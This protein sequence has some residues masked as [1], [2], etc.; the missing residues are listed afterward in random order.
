VQESENKP[1]PLPENGQSREQTTEH[2]FNVDELEVLRARSRLLHYQKMLDVYLDILGGKDSRYDKKYFYSIRDKSGLDWAVEIA[3]GAN[4]YSFGEKYS[5]DW[6]LALRIVFERFWPEIKSSYH[7]V[8]KNISETEEP[9]SFKSLLP[10]AEDGLVPIEAFDLGEF[11]DEVLVGLGVDWVF[12]KPFGQEKFTES[13]L[14]SLVENTDSK[15]FYENRALDIEEF[16]RR[17][18]YSKDFLKIGLENGVDINKTLWRNFQCL[19]LLVYQETNF[20]R[21]SELKKNGRFG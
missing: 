12:K 7:F 8:L 17:A 20:V 4:A 6:Q 9:E 19:S 14:T 5:I 15:T 11:S 1:L 10:S 18:D 21:F 13:K 2:I 16:S 3:Q